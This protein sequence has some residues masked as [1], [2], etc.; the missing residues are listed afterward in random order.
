MTKVRAF[1]DSNVERLISRKFLAWLTAT[2]LCITG[3]LDADNW[4]AVTMSYIGTQAL[5]D[6]ATKW[7]HGHKD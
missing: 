4:V 3:V 1:L 2:T 7:K 5:V 6:A